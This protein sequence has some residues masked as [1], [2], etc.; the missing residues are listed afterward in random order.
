MH[1]PESFGILKEHT[2]LRKADVCAV[3]EVRNGA[4]VGV[5]NVVGILSLGAVLSN[6]E[7]DG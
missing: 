4:Q 5:A 6:A 1:S 2:V 7:W 3:T